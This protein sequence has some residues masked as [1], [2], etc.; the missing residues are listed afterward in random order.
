MKGML[1]NRSLARAIAD[2][3]FHEL[4]R[5]LE[6]KAAWRGGRVVVADRWYPSSKLCSCCGHKLDTWRWQ[7]ASGPALAAVRCMTATS[8]R[9]SI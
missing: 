4:R 6:Y 3:G 8:M 1:G 5:Q 2:M 9:Q 7:C